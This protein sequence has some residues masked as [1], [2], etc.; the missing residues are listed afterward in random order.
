VDQM[1]LQTRRSRHLT[2]AKRQ[3]EQWR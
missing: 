3:V 1:Q 2:M